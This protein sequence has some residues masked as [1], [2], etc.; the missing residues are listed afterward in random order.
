MCGIC[1]II[2]FA[3]QSVD[4][5]ALE[6][7]CKLMR[8]RGPDDIGTWVGDGRA[9]AVGLGA[10]RLGILDPSPASNQPMHDHTGRYHVVFNG[11]LYNYRLL[12][13]ELIREGE[14]FITDGDTEV[15]LA[16]C[17]RWGTGAFPRFNGMWALAFYDSQERK[18]FLSRD[19]FGIKPLFYTVGDG[20]LSFA[21]ELQALATLGECGSDIDPQAVVQHLQFGYIAHPATIYKK[22]RR[23]APGHYLEFDASQAGPPVRYFSPTMDRRE[24]PIAEYGDACAALRRRLADAVGCRRVSDVEIGA[25]LSGGLDSSIVVRHLTE[26]IGG[27]IRTFSVGYEG[28][29]TYDETRF[30]RVVA[31]RFGTDHYELVLKEQDVVAAIP[32][33]LD[34]LGEPFGDSSIIPTSLLSRFARQFVTVALSGDGGDELFGGYW[35]YLGHESLRV[36]QRIPRIIRSLLVEPLL[37]ALGS[38]RSSTV[39]NRVRQLR[40]LLRSREADPLARHV[41]WSRILAPEAEDLLV[42]RR[43]VSACDAR[44]LGLARELTADLGLADPLNLILA[45]DLQ[46]Q[47]PAD[48]L[49]KVD[50]A[51]MMHSLE[52]RVPFLDPVV[53]G[54]VASLPSRAKIDRGLRK[55]ILTDAYLD[56]LPDEVLTRGKQGFEVPIGEFLRG[57]LREMFH[58]TVT[59]EVVESIGL[60]SHGA[61]AKIYREHLDRRS[62]HADLL[63]ALLSLCWWYTRRRGP[64]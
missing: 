10:A 59:R 15:V 7:A 17:A 13:R 45:F 44:T 16:A 36:Y 8:H 27:P 22:A 41:A 48:M 6:A 57:P 3:E 5:D 56:R 47:L 39:G 25:F 14:Y 34:H 4:R 31:K 30:A 63:F 40:K 55:R 50:L 49:H 1:G 62:D 35:R 32:R 58:D 23:L 64:G 38:S 19:R 18:G 42:D 43:H 9:G 61:V 51:S 12:R 2:H 46:H 37:G 24:G 21:S 33:V 28:Q 53:V 20:G 29:R 60:L 54:L 26:A 11:E 52:V